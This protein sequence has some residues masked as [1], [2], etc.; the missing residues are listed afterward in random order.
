MATTAKLVEAL[1]QVL[2]VSIAQV[3]HTARRLRE[4]GKLPD[5]GRGRGVSDIDATHGAILLVAM[6]ASDT[7]THAAAAVDEVDM[8]GGPVRATWK[9]RP[10][11]LA[12][13]GTFVTAVTHLIKQ[14]SNPETQGMWLNGVRRVGVTKFGDMEPYGWIEPQPSEHEPLTRVTFRGPNVVD[15][16]TFGREEVRNVSGAGKGRT[17]FELENVGPGLTRDV[18]V[19]CQVLMRIA[20]LL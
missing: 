4:A 7:A 1:S 20:F 3:H 8:I 17:A 2:L 15:K 9:G 6:L 19:G 12:P 16:L 18:S 14:L 5:E 10:I 13:R 11:E